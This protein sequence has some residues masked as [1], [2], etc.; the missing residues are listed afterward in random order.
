MKSFLLLSVFLTS[1]VWADSSALTADFKSLLSSSKISPIT[2]QAYCYTKGGFTHGYQPYKMQRIASITKLLST[3]LASE[4]M[5]LH[6]TFTTKIYVGKDSL[7]IDGGRDPYF[8]EEKLLLLFKALNELGRKSFKNV[9]FSRDF[10]FYDQA[11][12]SYEKVTPEKSRV[13]LETYLKNTKLIKNQWLSVRK[14]AREEGI[15]LDLNG[16]I[17]TSSSVSI[18]DK[19]PLKNENPAVYFHVSKPFHTLLK[20]MNVQ[21]KNVV[22]ENVYQAASSLK[23]FTALMNQKGIGQSTYKIYN[24]SGLPII[25]GELRS[26][27]LATCDMVLRVIGLLSESLKKHK[28]KLSD[29]VAINGGQDLGSFRDRFENQP[30]T[31]E[32]VISKTGTLKHTS[33][34]A[35]VLLT[36]NEL[37]FAILNHTTSAGAARKFQDRFIAKMFEHLGPAVPEDYRKISIFPWDGSDFLKPQ[38]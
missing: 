10:L 23:S 38:I 15:D 34:L 35:G 22:A 7:H 20:T 1:Q 19:N 6:Q 5:D 24:G 26:D 4:T 28:L 9:T 17:L 37:P 33:S 13:R 11:L 8:E 27:N 16:P 31:H 25:K 21:S 14:Y 3:Y 32:A 30:E 18:S 29:V 36:D 2:E 12:S